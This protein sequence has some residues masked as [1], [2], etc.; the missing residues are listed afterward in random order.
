MHNINLLACLLTYL[1]IHLVSQILA[2]TNCK[3]K[4]IFQ[5]PLHWHR[6]HVAK[7]KLTFIG[8]VLTF[9]KKHNQS[10]HLLSF[11]IFLKWIQ[12]HSWPAKLYYFI[13]TF[14]LHITS[15]ILL[16]ANQNV[17]SEILKATHW[18]NKRWLSFASLTSADT[19]KQ[20]ALRSQNSANDIHYTII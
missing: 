4:V 6:K 2:E 5:N 14:I 10:H 20:V 18:I 13:L 17:L 15:T 8:L 11:L 7:S 3:Q 12:A 9:L 19:I 16:I 1:L